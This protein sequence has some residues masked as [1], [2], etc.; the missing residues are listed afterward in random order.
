MHRK[1]IALIIGAALTVTS[2]TAAPAQAQS[3]GETAAIIAGVA[4]LAIVGSTL[5]NDRNRDR[6]SN[7]VTRGHGYKQPYYAPKRHHKPAY[8]PGHSRHQYN[9]NRHYQ[10]QRGYAR[11]HQNRH[12][13]QRGYG[14]HTSYDRNSHRK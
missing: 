7:H 5:A 14:N 4:A 6:H 8:N 1:F 11:P 3:R 9:Q 13:H 10:P 2:L 12:V